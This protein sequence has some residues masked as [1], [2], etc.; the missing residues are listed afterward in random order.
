MPV[1]FI[2]SIIC[3]Q[4]Q[5]TDKDEIYLVFKGKKV[6]PRDQKFFKIDVDDT[7]EVGMKMKINGKGWLKLELWEYDLTSKDD[8][9]GTFHLKIDDSTGEF[10]EM[11]TNTD[12]KSPVSYFLNW[13]IEQEAE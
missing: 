11:L 4:P 2:N 10:S 1:I 13:K 5:E 6:W 3:E 9:L 8:H 7:L 12:P